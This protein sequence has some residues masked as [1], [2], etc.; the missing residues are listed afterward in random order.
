M[1]LSALM[2]AAALTGSDPDGI[3]A[4]APATA[5]DLTAANRPVA[6]TAE[7]AARQAAEP[8]NLTTDQQIDRWIASRDPEARP[9][10][11]D[12][13]DRDP[14]GERKMHGEFTAGIGTGGYRD[15]GMAV[16]LPIGENGT[17]G[18]SYRQTRNGFGY[19]YGPGQY[20]YGG[21][22]RSPYFNDSGYSF[23]GRYEPENALEHERRIGRPGG[24]PQG[25]LDPFPATTPRY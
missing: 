18:L 2:M 21:Y 8:H 11:H 7:G 14:Q 6:P 3:V 10:A 15:Y 19:G 22:G 20:E 13:A 9:Y 4:T 23:P 25:S 16:T 1:V 24:L 12:A 5:V 17:L